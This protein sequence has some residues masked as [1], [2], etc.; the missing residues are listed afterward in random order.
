MRAPH[1]TDSLKFPP[2]QSLERKPDAGLLVGKTGFEP[3]F[4]RVNTRMDGSGAYVHVTSSQ[5][6]AAACLNKGGTTADSSLCGRSGLFCVM[7][8]K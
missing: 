3:I 2:E 5:V 1:G 8:M 6:L 4:D 7:R